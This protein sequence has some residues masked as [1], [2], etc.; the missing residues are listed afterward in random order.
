MVVPPSPRAS[1]VG[2]QGG[3][4]FYPANAVLDPDT[5]EPVKTFKG[6]KDT[7]LVGPCPALPPPPPPPPPPHSQVS[8]LLLYGSMLF[9][10]SAD[11]TIKVWKWAGDKVRLI[12][13]LGWAGQWGPSRARSAGAL[14]T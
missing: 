8:S 3:R 2:S 7:V 5:I 13:T 9:S 1:P 12:S 4:H 10:A 6:H 14:T 11:R